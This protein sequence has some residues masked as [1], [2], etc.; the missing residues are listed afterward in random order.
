MRDNRRKELKDLLKHL[1]PKEVVD[2]VYDY[3][4]DIK[5]CSREDLLSLAVSM[6]YGWE[7]YWL[8]LN[9]HR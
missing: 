7:I 8:H 2:E 6:K 5:D 1:I 9:K 3:Y 4:S